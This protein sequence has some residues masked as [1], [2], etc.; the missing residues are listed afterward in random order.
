MLIQLR[1]LLATSLNFSD[2][3]DSRQWRNAGLRNA[4]ALMQRRIH[5]LQ[6]PKDCSKARWV[7]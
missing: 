1:S 5:A 6:N 7:R 3:S 2:V 4:T